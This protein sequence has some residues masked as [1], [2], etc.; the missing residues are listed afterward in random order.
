MENYHE[1]YEYLEFFARKINDIGDPKRLAII[2][3]LKAHKKLTLSDISR[4]L[5]ID[6][7]ETRLHLEELR[8]NNLIVKTKNDNDELYM[9]RDRKFVKLLNSIKRSSYFLS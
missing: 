5:N 4:L 9:I 8:S 7:N 6:K 3:L 2:D 1:K